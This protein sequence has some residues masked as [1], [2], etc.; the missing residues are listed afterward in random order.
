MLSATLY[1]KCAIRVFREGENGIR[2]FLLR[3]VCHGYISCIWYRGWD[4]RCVAVGFFGVEGGS[5]VLHVI[6]VC[7]V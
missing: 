7:V 1:A 3:M 4:L 5:V 2:N 6:D